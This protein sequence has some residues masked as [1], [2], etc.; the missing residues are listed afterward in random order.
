VLLNGQKDKNTLYCSFCGKSQH[1][2]RKLIAGPTVFICNECTAL[3]MD[4]ITE[5]RKHLSVLWETD[6]EKAANPSY[7]YNDLDSKV[8]GPDRAIKVLA[9]LLACHNRNLAE[10]SNTLAPERPPLLALLRGSALARAEFTAK[11]SGLLPLP[12]FAVDALE[13]ANSGEAETISSKVALA[14]ASTANFNMER[15]GQGFVYFDDLATVL[16]PTGR[17]SERQANRSAELPSAL[18]RLQ[19]GEDIVPHGPRVHRLATGRITLI[20]GDRFRCLDGLPAAPWPDIAEDSDPP[21]PPLS[22]AQSEAL[23][24]S[25][26][27]PDLVAR[28]T[29]LIDL[30]E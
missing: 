3:C 6:K 5:E 18:L 29:T 1:D 14:L 19:S 26:L 7:L 8:P 21:P 28:V 10:G 23:I 24:A 17:S 9:W 2:V 20:L 15:A 22:E 16:G 13:A 11:L 25:G 30:E 4:I 27:P 12:F